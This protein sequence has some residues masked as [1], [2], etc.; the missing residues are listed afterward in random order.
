MK[1]V[2]LLVGSAKQPRSTSKSLGTYLLERLEEQGWEGMTMLVPHAFR[3]AEGQEEMLAAVDR[4]ALL[5]LAFPLYV[6]SLPALMTRGLEL[7]AA[8]RRAGGG[9]EGQRLVA[10]VNSGFPEAHQNEMALAICRQFARETGFEW[11]GGLALGGG[12]AINGKP[13]AQVSGLARNVVAALDL[14]A[15]A[16][17]VGQ[18]V[19]EKAVTLMA[20][21]LIPSRAYT[22]IGRRE[23]KRRARKNGAQDTL[24]ARPYRRTSIP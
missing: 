22:I 4:V 8:H 11:A 21:L 16:L 15:D 24:G 6:D 19:P 7:I 2:L 18:P 3:S 10:I 9:R 5:V 1:K 20:R 17:A 12:E 23:W 13:L 14:T